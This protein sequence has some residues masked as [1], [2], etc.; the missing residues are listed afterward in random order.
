MNAIPRKRELDGL[1]GEHRALRGLQGRD[2]GEAAEAIG[3]RSRHPTVQSTK[4]WS[5]KAREVA[6]PAP[7]LKEA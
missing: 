2:H 1:T 4:C 5:S 6:Y 3:F 7:R